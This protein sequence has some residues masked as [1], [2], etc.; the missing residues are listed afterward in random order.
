[1]NGS[2]EN[3]AHGASEKPGRREAL[4]NLATAQGMLPLVRRI[5]ADVLQQQHSLAQLHPE[6]NRLDRQRHTLSWPERSRRYQVQEEI[7]T[8]NQR[9]QEALV[10]LANLGVVLVN[11]QE[12]Q[13]GFPTV[14]NSRPA[15]FSWRPGEEQLRHWHHPEETVRRPI[16]ASWAKSAHIS[17]SPKP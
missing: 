15:Y 17:L 4:F 13:V 10:E 6:Q 3:T 5:V 8:A 16:P 2:T 12:G 9:L 11:A 1:M 7:A 14:V